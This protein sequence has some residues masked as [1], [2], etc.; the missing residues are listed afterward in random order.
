MGPVSFGQLLPLVLLGPKDLLAAAVDNLGWAQDIF[1]SCCRCPRMG[2]VS[3]GQ[4]L[5]MVSLGPTYLWAA[6]ANDLGWAQ[7]FF[8]S[9]Y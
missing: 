8:G 4:L 9:C 1:G 5:P 7:D 2:P 6:A 3:F